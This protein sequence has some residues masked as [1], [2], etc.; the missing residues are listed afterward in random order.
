MS[1]INVLIIGDIV[2]KPGRQA[3]RELLPDMQ[4]REK[5]HFTIAN[6][7]NLA[8]GSG[9]SEGTVEEIFQIGVDVITTGDHVFKRKDGYAVLKNN[10]HLLRPANY[11]LSPPGF[12]SCICAISDTVTIGVI[13]L[14]GRVFLSPIDCPFRTINNVIDEIKQKTNIIIVDFHAEATSEK[15]ALGWYVDG[16]VSAVCGTHTHVQTADEVVLPNGT[17]YISDV[18]MTGPTDSTTNSA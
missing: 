1:I 12:G 17:A 5:I 2:G 18:G 3:C 13:N 14:L 8:G 10:T 6:G 7:E 11:P 16:K 4:E 9:V 15:I